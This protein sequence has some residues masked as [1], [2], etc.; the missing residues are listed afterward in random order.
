MQPRPA[1]NITHKRIPRHF[2]PFMYHNG[3]HEKSSIEN[4][5]ALCFF[6]ICVVKDR[7][8]LG[9]SNL[10]I[11]YRIKYLYLHSTVIFALKFIAVNFNLFESGGFF[12]LWFYDWDRFSIFHGFNHKIDLLPKCKI[13]ELHHNLIVWISSIIL[14]TVHF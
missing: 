8:L 6:I 13:N 5:V 3:S 14:W 1:N 7:K 2:L 9:T 11:F 4:S 10:F 12:W